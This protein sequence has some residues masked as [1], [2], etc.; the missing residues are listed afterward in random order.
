MERTR[1]YEA[2]LRRTEHSVATQEKYL[3]DVTAFLVWL[4]ERELTKDETTAWKAQLAVQHAPATVNAALSALNGYLRFLNREDCRVRFLKVQRRIFREVGK[5]LTQSEFKRLIRTAR[6]K[7]RE[8]IALALETIGGTGIRVSELRFITVEA[9]QCGQTEISLKG[10]IRPIVLPKT[11]CTKLLAY[12]RKQ[13]IGVGE[14]FRTRSG[15]PLSR[16]QIWAEMKSLC[17]AAHVAPGKV[18]PHNLRH[19]FAVVFYKVYKDIVRLADLLGHS[20]INTT[21]IYLMTSG[22]EQRRQLD[23]LRLVQ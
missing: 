18:F 19:L 4:G 23:R 5:E 6:A 11:L 1:D 14:I 9:A 13:R 15:R 8:R 3:R 22:V 7:G 12:A 20:S 10:K 21:R 16:G 2:Y 17:A